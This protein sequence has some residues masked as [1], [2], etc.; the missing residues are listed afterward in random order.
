MNRKRII[1]VLA[2]ALLFVGASCLWV[3]LPEIIH[4]YNTDPTICFHKAFTKPR[5]K[6]QAARVYTRSKMMILETLKRD[7]IMRYP[8]PE[9][10]EKG[11]S[12]VPPDRLAD[13]WGKPY[14]YDLVDGKARLTSAGRDQIFGTSDDI[15]N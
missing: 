4:R 2:V 14:R 12:D 10:W 1:I 8:T 11:M 6:R 9:E 3:A 5:T 13:P 7:G 15:S